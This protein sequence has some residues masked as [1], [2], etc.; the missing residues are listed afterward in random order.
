[1]SNCVKCKRNQI[2]YFNLNNEGFCNSCYNNDRCSHCRN[3]VYKFYFDNL[4]EYKDFPFKHIGKSV[5]CINCKF[6]I[7]YNCRD[8][9][10]T[11]TNCHT[12][13]YKGNCGGCH[14]YTAEYASTS[15]QNDTT[16]TQCYDSE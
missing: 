15:T 4:E 8:N 6:L 3:S 13:K 16:S 14:E 5:R 7:C 10:Q 12:F 1:M 2:N 9:V 11:C